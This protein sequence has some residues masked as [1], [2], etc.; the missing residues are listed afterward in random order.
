[1]APSWFGRSNKDKK[2]R[3]KK[4]RPEQE[5]G[6]LADKEFTKAL[7][8]DIS[9]AAGWIKKQHGVKVSWSR[10]N[11]S[12]LAE[13]L[14]QKALDKALEDSSTRRSND[15]LDREIVKEAI[16][17][18]MMGKAPGSG[19]R[20]RLTRYK[21]QVVDDYLKKVYPVAAIRLVEDQERISRQVS[22]SPGEVGIRQL[23]AI[24]NK[25]YRDR[26]ALIKLA[27]SKQMVDG[28]YQG[29]VYVVEFKGKA[30]EMTQALYDRYL[31]YNNLLKV[32][33]ARMR[34]LASGIRDKVYDED[35]SSDDPGEIDEAAE[36]EGE[37]Y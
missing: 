21:K 34:G 26:E 10:D 3:R 23:Q 7:Q 13:Q 4:R 5:L 24:H 35:D 8:N 20:S 32:L 17:N 36:A 1:M 31:Q 22:P 25:M 33:E 14:I 9:V 11:L 19:K 29:H 16:L 6:R 27:A 12:E 28:D 37:D 30:V 18:R 2:N 15:P